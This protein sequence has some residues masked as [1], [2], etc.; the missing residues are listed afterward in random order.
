M[1][2]RKKLNI[3]IINVEIPINIGDKM[4]KYIINKFIIVNQNI[5]A[6]NSGSGLWVDIEDLIFINE[7]NNV[8]YFKIKNNGVGS[9]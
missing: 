4:D 7:K 8:K 5:Y 6:V 1:I 9:V 3:G 2:I